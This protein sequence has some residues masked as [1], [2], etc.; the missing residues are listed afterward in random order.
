M[1]D[2]PDVDIRYALLDIV[3]DLA[4]HSDTNGAKENIASDAKWVQLDFEE[5]LEKMDIAYLPRPEVFMSRVVM[6]F[7]AKQK[8]VF[9]KLV[10]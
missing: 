3:D 7:K 4:T 8:S 5:V 2:N 9:V 10:T 1:Y 6:E